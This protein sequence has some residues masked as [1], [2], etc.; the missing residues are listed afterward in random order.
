MNERPFAMPARKTALAQSAVMA[1]L[2]AG[3]A[4]VGPDFVA[5]AAPA[6]TRYT[7]DDPTRTDAG[8][9]EVGQRIAIDTAMPAAWW[10]AFESPDLDATVGLALAN[11]PTLETALATLAQARQNVT[12]ARGALYPQL[13]V[14]A[15]AG[16]GN[17]NSGRSASGA[18]NAS[19]ITPSA[20]YS[21]DAFG[22]TARRIEQ[23]EAL[24][25][26]QQAQWQAARLSLA[27]GVVL[28]AIAL[29]A[30]IEEARAVQDI[31]AADQ[32]NLE[33]VQV[34]AAAG[35]S[36]GLDVLTAESQLAGD[37]ALLPP[38][39]QSASAAR[40]ALAVLAGKAPVEWTPPAFDFASLALPRELP[41]ALPSQLVR[42]R[43]DIQAAEAQLHAA[44]A[45]IGVAT[46]QLYPS[47]TLTA[48]WTAAAGSGGALFASPFNLWGIAAGLV[49]PVFSGG[50]LSAQRDAA[51]DA[52]A[53]QL[54]T[55]RQTVLQAFGQVA[56]ALAAL[57]NAAALLDAQRKALDAAQATLDLTQ[58]SFEAGQASFLQIFAAQ[59][60]YQQ[61]RLGY[62][63]AKSQRYADSAQLFVA[64][65][66]AVAQPQ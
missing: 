43:P 53:A 42:H 63:Q 37:R 29:A 35:K 19:A 22:A 55:Y 10:Q 49:A 59:R 3:C 64:I 62:V 8:S 34:S 47:I 26:V 52:Y 39:L 25:D 20:S 60:L 41:L 40:H 16:R 32:R 28:Q 2:L 21:L 9:A 23:T 15:S 4:A 30:A 13:A 38:L 45:A 24:A 7:S 44:N 18:V 31:I 61:A 27:S 5:P 36:A 50:T 48:Q 54:G 17:L 33:L 11:S 1:S 51:I 57:S 58:Q 66:G 14:D 6:L 65:G 46:A 12:A 56:D